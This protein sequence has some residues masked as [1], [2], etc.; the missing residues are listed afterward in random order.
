MLFPGPGVEALDKAFEADG[1]AAG[2]FATVDVTTQGNY[3]IEQV[4]VA[5]RLAGLVFGQPV[6]QA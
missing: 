6:A 5:E 2:H 4:D 1:P 3:P